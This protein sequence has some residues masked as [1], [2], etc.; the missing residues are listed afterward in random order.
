MERIII[1]IK[2]GSAAFGEEPGSEIGRILHALAKSFEN[3]GIPPEQVR[4]LN[5]HVC[6]SVRME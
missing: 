5:G 1:T 3:G 4:D 2:T 6:G